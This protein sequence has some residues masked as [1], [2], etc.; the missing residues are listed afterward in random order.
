MNPY[1]AHG[2]YVHR[3]DDHRVAPLPSEA[4][5]EAAA[6]KLNRRTLHPDALFWQEPEPDPSDATLA[7]V[8][9]KP[10]EGVP[11]A[12]ASGR[13]FVQPVEPP[14]RGWVGPWALKAWPFAAFLIGGLIV[15]WL[16]GTSGERAAGSCEAVAEELVSILTVTTDEVVV[17]QGAAIE[18]LVDHA[19]YG[20]DPAELEA[21]GNDLFTISDSLGAITDRYDAV[22]GDYAGCVK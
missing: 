12:P 7:A 18:A 16:V 17:P 19:I 1:Y 14:P 2:R 6:D 15:G 10:V 13:P 5:A 22:S 8:A 20:A 21:I 3:P 9:I 11:V 4:E